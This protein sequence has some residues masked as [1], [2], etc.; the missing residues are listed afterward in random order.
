MP[1]DRQYA[2]VLNSGTTNCRPTRRQSDQIK[3]FPERVHRGRNNLHRLGDQQPAAPGHRHRDELHGSTDH[4]EQPG[5]AQQY[6]RRPD[7][8]HLYEEFQPQSRADRVSPAWWASA[9]GRSPWSPLRASSQY[10][11]LAA[12]WTATPKLGLTASAS[13]TVSPPTSIIANLQVTESANLGLTYS[14]T[15][16]VLLAAGVGASRSSGAYA[17]LANASTSQPGLSAVHRELEHV[18]S[19]NASI[20]YAITPFVTANLSYTHTKIRAGKLRDAHRRGLACIDLQTRIETPK[21][22]RGRCE[23]KLD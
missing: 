12:T 14:L 22:E 13:Q 10:T 21:L 19:A 18:Y 1:R 20:N 3:R 8:S 6:N 15:P 4:S 7:Q 2:W 16:K 5:L 9:T 23:R 17:A 11:P